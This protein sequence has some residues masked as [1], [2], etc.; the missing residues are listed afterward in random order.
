MGV[1]L[2]RKI[3]NGGSAQDHTE[4]T[5]EVG[6][7]LHTRVKA[8][9]GIAGGNLGLTNCNGMNVIPT[10]SDIDDFNPVLTIVSGPFKYL[11]ELNKGGDA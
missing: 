7:S 10:C 4:G 11:S 6:P 5:Y 2:A 9:V 8:F 1:A 3:I